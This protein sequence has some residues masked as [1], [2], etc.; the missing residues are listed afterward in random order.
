MTHIVSITPNPHRLLRLA[1]RER[2]LPPGEDLGYTW[3]AVLAAA[4]GERAPKPFRWFQPNTREGGTCGKLLGYSSFSIE[5][6][7]EHA[8]YA[9]PQFTEVLHLD[10]AASK[11]MPTEFAAS[12]QL[13]FQVRL[14]PVRRVGAQPDGSKA[15]ER[16]VYDPEGKASRE[17]AYCEWLTDRMESRGAEILNLRVDAMLLT[18]LLTR[19]RTS[20]KSKRMA[21][22]GPDV[23]ISG[24]LRV[25]DPELFPA[26]IERGIGRHRAFGFG[27]L[28]LKPE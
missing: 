23:T 12:R 26:L 25:S 5:E 17:T 19:D 16:D 10:E 1:V 13:R 24:L 14:R 7:R 11:R 2:L 3:H 21:I 22:T 6:L 4:F 18:R 15:T 9:D 28:L 20:E 27:M 8:A